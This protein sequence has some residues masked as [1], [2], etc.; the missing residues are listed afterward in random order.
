MVLKT[1]CAPNLNVSWC[2]LIN[3]FTTPLYS[4]SMHFKSSSTSSSIS[5][6]FNNRSLSSTFQNIGWSSISRL[7]MMSR[8]GLH[9]DL[10][11]VNS[12]IRTRRSGIHFD[13][14]KKYNSFYTYMHSRTS[15]G[16]NQKVTLES[17]K[18]YCIIFIISFELIRHWCK[19][20]YQKCYIKDI[21][22]HS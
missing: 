8:Y 5:V 13:L 3:L 22:S 6:S 16:K 12:Y 15:M 10:G 20:V 9:K 19:S 1:L 18:T 11:L 4:F 14:D 2:F 7:G 21:F 17:I